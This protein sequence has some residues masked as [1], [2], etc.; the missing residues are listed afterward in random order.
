MKQ[1]QQIFQNMFRAIKGNVE[2]HFKGKN[3]AHKKLES[4]FYLNQIYF[5]EGFMHENLHAFYKGL[6]DLKIE[7]FEIALAESKKAY[8]A[9]IINFDFSYS[10]D[11]L[12]NLTQQ[13]T[14]DLYKE[15]LKIVDNLLAYIK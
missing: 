8:E 4:G 15:R 1:R 14:L 3:I 13:W 2:D 9:K 5:K 6:L 12:S 11:L 10:T 7:N